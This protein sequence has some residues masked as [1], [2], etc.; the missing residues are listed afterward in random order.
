MLRGFI[1][2]LMSDALD[3]DDYVEITAIINS[4]LATYLNFFKETASFLERYITQL[5]KETLTSIVRRIQTQITHAFEVETEGHIE[6]AN[7]AIQVLDCFH[8]ANLKREEQDK[9]PH[10]E[11]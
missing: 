10:S 1:I 11:F 8:K 6:N 7:E 2:L 9:V 4:Q 5:T 3:S